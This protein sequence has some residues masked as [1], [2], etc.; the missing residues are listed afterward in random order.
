M[1]DDNRQ[2]KLLGTLV[3]HRVV[4]NKWIWS[5]IRGGYYMNVSKSMVP[6]VAGIYQWNAGLYQWNVGLYGNVSAFSKEGP[7]SSLDD[8]VR[9]AHLAIAWYLREVE[10]VHE[11]VLRVETPPEVASRYKREPVI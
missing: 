3:D 11:F 6:D 7:G 10:A 1:P 2:L 5:A 4:N 8:C 9:Q